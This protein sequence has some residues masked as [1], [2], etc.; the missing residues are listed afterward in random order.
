M[1]QAT[2]A[3]CYNLVF[4]PRS[5]H[6]IQKRLKNANPSVIIQ[7]MEKPVSK[8]V[9]RDRPWNLSRRI[10]RNVSSVRTDTS[11]D[12]LGFNVGDRSVVFAVND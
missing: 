11:Y 3:R 10:N 7:V 6:I 4:D 8:L 1:Q 12:V 5:R 9:G 2:Y